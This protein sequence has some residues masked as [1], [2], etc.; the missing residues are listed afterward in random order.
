MTPRELEEKRDEIRAALYDILD[1]NET[2]F[3]AL[4]DIYSHCL[5]AD[6]NNWEEVINEIKEIA[7]HLT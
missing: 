7:G 2:M 6:E 1:D 5:A 3:C 4:V